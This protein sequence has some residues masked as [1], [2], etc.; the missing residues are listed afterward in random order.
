MWSEVKFQHLTGILVR[1]SL[2]Q[3]RKDSQGETIYWM[4]RPVHEWIST[5]LKS[6]KT[7][8]RAM[9]LTALKSID[10]AIPEDDDIRLPQ[11]FHRELF[12]HIQL[13]KKFILSIFGSST[14]GT[15]GEFGLV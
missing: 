15:C 10:H 9:Q 3:V 5:R 6:D 2:I 12:P 14:G 7:K 13:Y 4:H 1:F 11:E 8:E